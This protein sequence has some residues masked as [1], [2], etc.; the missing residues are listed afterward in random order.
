MARSLFVHVRDQ[1]MGALALFLVLSGG[2]AYAATSIGPGDIED[3]AVLSRHIKNGQVKE[4]DLA[5]PDRWHE[6]GPGSADEDLCSDPANVAV[7]CS[8]P[9]GAEPW[10]PWE[11]F[12]GQFASAGFHTGPGNIVHLKG[13][14]RNVLAVGS[15][16]PIEHPIFRLPSRDRP[17]SELVFASMS[18]E[19]ARGLDVSAARVD[20]QPNGFVVLHQDCTAGFT[21]CGGS[22]GYV[23]LDG[24]SFRPDE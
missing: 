7:F 13:L 5:Q 10:S 8:V 9:T 21:Q 14:V 19:P 17:N 6:V 18:Q 15:T 12:G 3:N 24:I 22:A 11:N 4:S 20:V 23:S 1:W 16:D 2:L